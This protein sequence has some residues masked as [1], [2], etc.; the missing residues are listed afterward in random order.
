[1]VEG[2]K[3]YP[4]NVIRVCIDQTGPD[5]AGR[6]YTP[7]KKDAVMFSGIT[8]FLIQMDRIFDERGYPQSFQ[9]KRSFLEQKRIENRY[10]GIPKEDMSLDFILQQRGKCVTMLVVVNSRRN[11]SW[12]G[13]VFS[14]EGEKLIDFDGEISF[15]LYREYK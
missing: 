4:V 5:L 9:N 1:M 6:A 10:A 7:L 3:T 8:D 2:I 14:I 11:T 12:Q 15:A 13:S